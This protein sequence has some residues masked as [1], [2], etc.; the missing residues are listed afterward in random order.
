MQIRR[1]QT[2][3]NQETFCCEARIPLRRPK[4]ETFRINING[5]VR[6]GRLIIKALDVEY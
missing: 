4:E 1:K 2:G 3:L 6:I 5:D